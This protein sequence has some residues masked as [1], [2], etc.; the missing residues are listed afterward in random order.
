VLR[1]ALRRVLR[2]ERGVPSALPPPPAR[3]GSE[4]RTLAAQL[5]LEEA[6]VA[7]AFAR[8]C[9]LLDPVLSGTVPDEARWDPVSRSWQ[10][11]RGQ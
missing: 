9:A 5:G 1:V 2:A 8:A 7:Q 3:W 10:P 11:G 6:T 4:Y